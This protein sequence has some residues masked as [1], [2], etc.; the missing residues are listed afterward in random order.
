MA[1]GCLAGGSGG[2]GLIDGGCT[3]NRPKHTRSVESLRIGFILGARAVVMASY[4]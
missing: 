1:G 3:E 2:W 4:G